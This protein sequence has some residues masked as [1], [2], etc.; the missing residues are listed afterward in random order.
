[1][2]EDSG[3]ILERFAEGGPRS[4]SSDDAAG[5]TDIAE[6]GQQKDRPEDRGCGAIF[7]QNPYRQRRRRD[8]RSRRRR[9]R[10]N[11]TPPDFRFYSTTFRLNG[12]R[13]RADH[14]PD[15]QSGFV[16]RSV[17]RRVMLKHV[18]RMENTCSVQGLTRL[19]W[20]W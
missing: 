4:P 11:P 16:A 6:I 12:D 7:S 14:T 1:M 18:L 20:G 15:G 5:C 17:L 10:F 2:L 3:V 8:G 9:Q 13:G 19:A